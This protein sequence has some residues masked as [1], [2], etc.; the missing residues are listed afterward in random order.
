M[1][2]TLTSR[3]IRTSLKSLTSSYRPSH[4]RKFS[5]TNIMSKE[6]IEELQS[7]PFYDK[8]AEKIAKLQKTSPEEFLSRLAEKETK[9]QSLS[10]KPQDFFMPTAPKPNSEGS[11]QS[12]MGNKGKTLEKIMKTE[13]LKDKTAEEVSSIWNEHF[14]S[15]DAVAA[16]IPAETFD[17][18]QERFKKFNTFLFPLPRDQGYEFVVV[19]FL[20][21]EAHFTTLINYQAHKENAPE[22]LSMVHYTELAEDKGIVLM[23]GEYDKDVLGPREAKCLADQVEIYYSRP[24]PRKLELLEEFTERPAFFKHMDL[25]DEMN[26]LS[27]E[28]NSVTASAGQS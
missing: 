15:K 22:C 21:K 18:M 16:V 26:N 7:N 25:V 13:L 19:Q 27:L 1:A 11:M 8:Y 14:S 2:L 17:V 4:L 3:F 12:A 24:S 10:L 6:Q 20:G 28:P 23:V 9:K 5:S